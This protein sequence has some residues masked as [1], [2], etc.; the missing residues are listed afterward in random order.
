MSKWYSNGNY[1]NY[2]GKEMSSQDLKQVS[3]NEG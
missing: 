3:R 1:V 2:K